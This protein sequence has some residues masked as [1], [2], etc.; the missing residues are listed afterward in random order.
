MCKLHKGDMQSHHV[1]SICI[2]PGCC[3]QR[4]PAFRRAL[5]RQRG[6]SKQG[7]RQH[8]WKMIKE[9]FFYTLPW[10][11]KR[12]CLVYEPKQMGWA[13]IR[14]KLEKEEKGIWAKEEEKW[15]WEIGWC[16]QGAKGVCWAI[17][18]RWAASLA[19]GAVGKCKLSLLGT[20]GTR[21]MR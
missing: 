19:H 10:R 5:H 17:S 18:R 2:V 15:G 20:K 13:E 1:W 8:T 16:S 6:L 11:V 4:T 14:H 7:P 12:K 9:C 21:H 3:L